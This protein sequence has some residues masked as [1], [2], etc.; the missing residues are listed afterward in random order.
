MLPVAAQLPVTGSNSSAVA[1][2]VVPFMPSATRT[3]PSFS[4]AAIWRLRRVVMLPVRVQ[5]L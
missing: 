2:A 5:A 3:L 1:S 4:S